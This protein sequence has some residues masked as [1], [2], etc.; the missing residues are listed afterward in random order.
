[1]SGLYRYQKQMS[2][3]L[4]SICCNAHALPRKHFVIKTNRRTAFRLGRGSANGLCVRVS[5]LFSFLNEYVKMQKFLFLLII[6]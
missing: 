5:I 6:V 3:L 4:L 2:T 1:M